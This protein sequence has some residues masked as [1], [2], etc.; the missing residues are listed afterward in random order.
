MKYRILGRTE[1]RVSEIGYGAWGIGGNLWQGSNDHES[2]RALH[3]AIDCGLTFID[4]AL[5]YGDGHS[6]RLINNVLEERREKITVATKI[7][8]KNMRWPAKKGSSLSE[9][10]PYTHIIECTEMSLKNLGVEQ[11]ELQQFHVWD[12]EWT[13]ESEWSDAI[14]HLKEQGKIR[15]FGVSINDYEPH[16]AL[17]LCHS[18]KLDTVQVIY[19]IF[20]Q[21]PEKEL[22]P[23]CMEKNIGV[24]VRVPLDEGGLT[25]TITIDTTFPEGDFRNRY[26]R[27]DRKEQLVE[28]TDRLKLLLGD[29]S[30]SLAELA[31]RFCL[32][33]AAVSTVIP[34]MR[35]IKNVEANIKVSDGQKLGESM[36]WNL[37][38]HQWIRNFYH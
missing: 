11:I 23:L 29:E 13:E 18:G 32:N 8:P 16:N 14:S 2:I 20:D 35:T 33:H 21:S 4:T 1:M 3:R 28:H 19:N 12:D 7:P 27:D 37:K 17:K 6:E 10:F 25:G 34:G 5:V 24:I 31:L 36:I 22:F 15:S 30:S 26:F 38:E 9:V